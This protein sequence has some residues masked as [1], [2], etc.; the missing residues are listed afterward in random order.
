VPEPARI[1]PARPDPGLA[2]LL[3]VARFLGVP[4]DAE[5]LRRRFAPSGQ[6]FGEAELVRAARALGLRARGL[7]SRWRRLRMTPLPALALRKDG[8]VVVLAAA[9]ADRALVQEGDGGPVTVLSRAGFAEAWSGRLILL[10]RPAP[11]GGAERAFGFGWFL[12]AIARHRGAL[13]EVLAASFV[14]QVFALL[15]PLFTQLVIDKVLVHRGLTTLDVLAVG[16][17]VLVVFETVLGALRGYL[18]AHVGSRMDV[19]LGAR[20]F[21]HLLGLPLAYFQARRVGDSVARVRELESIRQFLTGAPLTALLDVAFTAV[22]LAAMAAYSVVLTGIV[23]AALPICAGLAVGVGPALRAR[24]EERVSR[25]AESHAF[26]TECVRGVETVKALAAEGVMVRRWEEQ[27]AGVVR[28]AL[29]ATTLATVASQATSGLN[30]LAA[31]AVLWVGARA[32]MAGELTVGEL[33]AFNMLAGRVSAPV[34]RLAQ[35]WQECQ[36]A[37]IAVRRLADVLNAPAEA[38]RT[39]G[40]PPRLAGRVTFDAVTFR[41]RPEGPEVLRDASF[42]VGPG[43]VVAIVGRSGSG[44]STIARLVQRL[45]VPERGRVLVDGAD[46]SRLDP[47]WLRRRIGLV[48]QDALLWSGSVRE[49]IALADP[50]MPIERI[51]AAARLAGAHEFILEL[52]GGY[53]AVVG[54][55]GS[56]LSGGQRQRIAIARALAADPTVL[57]LD[58]ATSALD[59]ESE[60]AILR[61]LDAI[62]RGRTV[63]IIAHRMSLVRRAPRVLVL[64]RGR[65]VA[66]GPPGQVLPDERASAPPGA[67]GA[68]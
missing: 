57:I 23:V 53:E 62:C 30:R 60:R 67:G 15:T 18:V 6:P 21:R 58:E 32:A 51:V 27:L 35:L 66:D 7:R 22:F 54:E 1:G 26:L 33:V 44:K 42:T 36:R 31:L 28:A 46:V 64:E 63:L 4:A 56:T 13:A 19:E 41:Y 25:G 39:T 34:M 47:A 29:R 45:G 48:P 9:H 24:V 43:E 50:G 59:H 38:T 14:L 12:P 11:E 3:T 2:C 49:N 55:H 65:I 5:E 61:N 68:G 8:R 40:S 20:L 16:M 17:L 10:A 37:G 52:P